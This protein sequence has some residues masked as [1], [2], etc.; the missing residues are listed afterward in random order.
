MYLSGLGADFSAADAASL[1][2]SPVT[3][4]SS[5][6]NRGVDPVTYQRTYVDPTPNGQWL[7]E[8]G[9]TGPL[10]VWPGRK[11]DVPMV[12]V[13]YG[14]QTEFRPG[15]PP[16]ASRALWFVTDPVNEIGGWYY[17]PVVD[18]E[19]AKGLTQQVAYRG[20]MRYH[21]YVNSA[22]KQVGPIVEFA[23]GGDAVV[24]KIVKVLA[25][26]MIGTGVAQA[27]TA[28][29]KAVA[30]SLTPAAPSSSLP[31]AGTT[32]AKAA[33]AVAPAA[34]PAVATVAPAAAAIA[35]VAAGGAGTIATAASGLLPVLGTVAKGASALVP[36]VK[37]VQAVKA[38]EA[39]T[40]ARQDVMMPVAPPAN[41][42]DRTSPG[43]LVTFPDSSPPAWMIPALIGGA[44]LLFL[45]MKR[46]R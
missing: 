8:I 32:A 46:R 42:V 33:A 3:Y 5:T 31:S 26:A 12:Q 19:K 20:T 24:G 25:I 18:F 9:F 14:E 27:A 23:A 16:E 17:T 38:K 29:A 41:L 30:P 4:Q 40:K 15:R 22:G 6:D 45:L 10:G 2:W 36:V 44:G 1:N 43:S 13:G 35:P 7:K 21:R 11:V 28:A 39:E 34:A 37:A